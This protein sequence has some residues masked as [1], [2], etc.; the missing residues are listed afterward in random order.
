M[1]DLRTVDDATAAFARA[2]LLEVTPN[3]TVGGP[4]GAV[5]EAENV[6]SVLFDNT[7]SG[8][9]G[10][11]WTVTLSYVDGPNSPSVV[12]LELMPGESALLAPEWVP[13]ADR[14]ADYNAA[15]VLDGTDA[16]SE[17]EA[18]DDLETDD[19]DLDLDGVEFEDVDEDLDDSSDDDDSDDEEADDDVDDDETG[20]DESDLD[21]SDD[22]E[23]ERF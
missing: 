12:E 22:D 9:P 6:I 10:W 18:D 23:H 15:K 16:D 19:D 5:D 13:W 7:M 11:H 14:L 21:E 8:Y 3:D 17:D 20:D 2:A 1:P 4:L